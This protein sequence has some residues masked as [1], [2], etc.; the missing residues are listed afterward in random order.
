MVHGCRREEVSADHPLTGGDDMNDTTITRALVG[1]IRVLVVLALLLA[2]VTAGVL[3]AG[4]ASARSGELPDAGF[5]TVDCGAIGVVKVAGYGSGLGFG[6]DGSIWR[7]QQGPMNGLEGGH[8]C[9]WD[10]DG[11]TREAAV[12]RI[13]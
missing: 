4:P 13:R 12:M 6:D 10:D 5:W 11:V 3:A 1:P 7:R 9:T 2:L 8:T